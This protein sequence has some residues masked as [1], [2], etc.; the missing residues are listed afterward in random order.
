[1]GVIDVYFV[2][3]V[4]EV[5]LPTKCNRLRLNHLSTSWS[6]ITGFNFSPFFCQFLSYR[7]RDTAPDGSSPQGYSRIFS[8]IGSKI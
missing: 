2:D 1:M 6:F 5:L 3:N 8:G 4:V 7:V